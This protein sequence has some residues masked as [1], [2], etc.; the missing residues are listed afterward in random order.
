MDGE[1]EFLS[2]AADAF[3]ENDLIGAVRGLIEDTARHVTDAV[4]DALGRR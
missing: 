3:D 1:P 2:D 4:N